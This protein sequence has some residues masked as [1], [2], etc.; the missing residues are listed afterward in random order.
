MFNILRQK[1]TKNEKK[2]ECIEI[3]VANSALVYEKISKYRRVKHLAFVMRLQLC[4][5][6]RL[7]FL[8]YPIDMKWYDILICKVY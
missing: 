1:T 8:R 6:Y 5:F 3:I 2:H 4:F 7:S